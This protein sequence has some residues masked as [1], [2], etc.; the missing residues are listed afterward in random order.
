MTDSRKHLLSCRQRCRQG[1][2]DCERALPPVLFDEARPEFGREL[3]AGRIHQRARTLPLLL[4]R[5]APAAQLVCPLRHESV[6][7]GVSFPAGPLSRG[8]MI[9]GFTGRV[10]AGRALINLRVL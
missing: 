5:R 4:P 7:P 8:E 9:Y 1:S 6:P 3:I 10:S 2:K